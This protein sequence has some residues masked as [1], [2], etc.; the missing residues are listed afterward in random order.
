[1]ICSLPLVVCCLGITPALPNTVVFGISRYQFCLGCIYSSGVCGGCVLPG[2]A[3]QPV[4]QPDGRPVV[5]PCL[6]VREK[7]VYCPLYLD[8]ESFISLTH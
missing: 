3:T 6:E 4:D 5:H 7:S 8:V 1:M 2:C